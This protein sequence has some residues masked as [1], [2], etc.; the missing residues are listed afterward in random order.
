M[1]QIMG[2]VGGYWFN[3]RAGKEMTGVGDEINVRNEGRQAP[4]S[5]LSLCLVLF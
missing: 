2:N 1:D 4:R 5:S 3:Q